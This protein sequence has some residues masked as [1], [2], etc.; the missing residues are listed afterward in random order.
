MRGIGCRFHRGAFVAGAAVV[1]IPVLA[2]VLWVVTAVELPS[3][4]AALSVEDED[5]PLSADEGIPFP[6][7]ARQ[8]QKRTSSRLNHL[9]SYV[10]C[11]LL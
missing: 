10:P 3:V 9:F 1:G 8:R 6:A 4:E 11:A 2:V 7:A 5:A